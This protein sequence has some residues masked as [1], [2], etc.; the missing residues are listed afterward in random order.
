MSALTTLLAL[1]RLR[2]VRGRALTFVV[3]T[4]LFV[5]LI[6]FAARYAGAASS[7]ALEDE[8]A[9][10][11]LFRFLALLAPCAFAAGT[12]VDELTGRTLVYLTVRPVPRA[13]LVLGKW[14]AS[15]FAAGALVV[16]TAF[17]LHAVCSA[18]AAPGFF[19][20]LDHTARIALAGLLE[21]LVCTSICLA[22]GVV[23]ARGG[24]MLSF[25]F[26]AFFELL[27]S[28]A[29]GRL[30]LLSMAHHALALAGLDDAESALEVPALGATT[31]VLVM[32][33]V[34]GVWLALAALVFSAREYRGSEG[35]SA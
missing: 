15:A 17:A 6:A 18:F 10:V 1:E 21:S 30:R 35:E 32:L 29:P 26:I 34:A 23:A 3:A 31:H 4:A 25:A 14:L 28:M 16:V 7:A 2:L 24:S 11:G 13:T 27:V 33:V 9:R 12:I 22:F 5:V 20:G 8:A 19:A